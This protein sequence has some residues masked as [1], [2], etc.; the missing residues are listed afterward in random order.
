MSRATDK[1][2]DSL[3][4]VTAQQLADTIRNGVIV[5]DK[6]GNAV[7]GMDGQ[8]LRNP[9]PAAYIAAAIKFLKDNDITADPGAGRFDPLKNAIG[10]IPDFDE[11]SY[12][13]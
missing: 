10:D 6:E 7:I 11:D 3:H 5:T 12:S 4:Q 13:H 8:P 1:L 2:L 9:A